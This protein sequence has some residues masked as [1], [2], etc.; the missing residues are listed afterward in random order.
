MV[1]VLL[2]VQSVNL[3]II[4]VIDKAEGDFCYLV[5]M[6]PARL[7]GL[8]CFSSLPAAIRLE[9]LNPARACTRTRK[10]EAH[11]AS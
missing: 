2:Y 8:L 9:G 11:A 10:A 4:H 6:A 5:K 7:V 1:V 3:S